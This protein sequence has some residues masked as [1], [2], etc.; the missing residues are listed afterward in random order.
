MLADRGLAGVQLFG[1]LGEA[2]VLV[3]GDEYF[4]VSS[5]DGS[6]PQVKVYLAQIFV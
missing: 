5:F 1:G 6:C 3:N 4:Q 2:S